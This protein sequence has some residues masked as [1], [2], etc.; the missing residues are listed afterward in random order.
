MRNLRSLLIVLL[1]ILLFWFMKFYLKVPTAE[2]EI[3]GII[4]TAASILFGFLAG[5]FIS[6]L[7]NRYTEIRSLQGERSSAGVTMISYAENFYTEN[8]FESE[9]RKLVEKSA[10]VDEVI[11]WNEGHVEI[12][13]F[14]AI[15]KSFNLI[16][17]KK[18]K[19]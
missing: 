1:T 5:F 15:Q 3:I 14:Q 11:N 10:I 16:K 8:K 2:I 7:W 4:L 17:I 6:E 19:G 18:I 13:Y 9:F 12:P